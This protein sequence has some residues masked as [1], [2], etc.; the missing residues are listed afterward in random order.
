MVH[1]NFRLIDLR[2]TFQDSF[3]IQCCF[4]QR[5]DRQTKKSQR[6]HKL[7]KLF[8]ESLI[9]SPFQLLP[10]LFLYIYIYT[11]GSRRGIKRKKHEQHFEKLHK[12]SHNFDNSAA[13]RVQNKVVLR[14]DHPN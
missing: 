1:V 4:C 11:F 3:A 2:F 8:L 5:F 14:P 13:S 10:F 6:F 9:V 7:I 12:L